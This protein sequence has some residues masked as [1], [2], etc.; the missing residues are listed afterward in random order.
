MTYTIRQ[1]RELKGLTQAEMASR[2]GMARE[3]Y[4]KI[5]AEPMKA[6][7]EQIGRI[8]EITG[9]AAAGAPEG[10]ERAVEFSVRV[11]PGR[12]FEVIAAAVEEI[13]QAYPGAKVRVEL[14]V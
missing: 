11:T 5:E 10:S 1:A 4:R 7:M 12:K 13:M 9:R 6:T 8:A 3:T 14:T 2:L